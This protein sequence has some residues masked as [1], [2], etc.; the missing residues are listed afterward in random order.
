[1]RGLWRGENWMMNALR[2]V[3]LAQKPRGMYSLYAGLTLGETVGRSGGATVRLEPYRSVEESTIL[4]GQ[5]L[6]NVGKV[7][8]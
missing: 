2:G 6:R 3:A 4:T 5:G 1:M 8:M 7:I